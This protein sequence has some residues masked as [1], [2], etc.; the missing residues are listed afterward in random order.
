[1]GVVRSHYANPRITCVIWIFQFTSS[2][3]LLVE[4][5]G[6]KFQDQCGSSMCTKCTR[7][8][9]PSIESSLSS[10]LA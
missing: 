1:V 8:E 7:Q 3:H 9:N 2:T 10:S 6:S 5:G 4:T